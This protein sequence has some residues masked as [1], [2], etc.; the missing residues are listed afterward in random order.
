M[1]Y[2]EVCDFGNL[3][4]AGEKCCKAGRWKASIQRFE[5]DLLLNTTRN[6]IKLETGNISL[7]PTNNFRISERGKTRKIKAHYITDRQLLKSF[8]EY[9][10]KPQIKSKII[11]SNAASQKGRGTDYS[12][13]LFR[14]D[15]T[16]AYRKWGKNFYVVVGD[17]HDYFGSESHNEIL[18]Q[19]RFK[20][21]RSNK[22]LK[23]YLDCFPGDTGIGI[24]G[25]P[26]QDISVV[27][28]SKIDRMLACD[29]NVLANGRYM[30]NFYFI[31]HD[32]DTA[33]YTLIRIKEKSESIGLTLNKKVTRIY[34]MSTDTVTWLKKRTYIT[35][36]GKI[37]MR[38]TRKNVRSAHKSIDFYKSKIDDGIIPREC[39]DI[40][41]VCWSS[42]AK[43]YN[44]YNQMA[45]VISHYSKAFNEQKQRVNILYKKHPKGFIK[46]KQHTLKDDIE[47][48]KRIRSERIAFII[49]NS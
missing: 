14:Q 5:I 22:I 1:S 45:S 29:P 39:A 3:L 36:T 6:K 41:I 40:S 44:S 31:V 18:N 33:N 8:C 16:K 20:D 13:I 17:Y 34:N 37:V 48:Y 38:L 15:L 30:D 27:F 46:T 4:H 12:I 26:S 19:I 21:Y 32:K 24:G 23:E 7:K 25:E 10:L 42:Y 11:K 28:A 49:H 35:D 9:E 47:Y 43:P 2:E